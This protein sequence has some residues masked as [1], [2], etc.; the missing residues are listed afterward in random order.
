MLALAAQLGAAATIAATAPA[1]TAASGD[2]VWRELSQRTAGGAD[3]YRGLALTAA[4]QV[5]AAGVTAA[6][7]GA[8]G[9][10]LVRKYSPGG[11][12]LWRR[13]WTWP[14]RSDD[15]AS[16]VARDRRGSFIV[17]GSSGSC[18]LLLKYSAGGYLQWVRRARGQF[19][20]C[21]LTAVAVDGSGD[22]YAAGAATPA[23]GD[24]RIL[25]VKYSSAGA[26]RWQ[27]TLPSA[28]GDAAAAGVALGGGDVYISGR[29]ATGPGTSAATTVKYS[30]G[31]VRRWVRSYAAAPADRA[32]ATSIGFASGP[33]VAGW[34]AAGNAL[35]QGFCVHYTPDGTQSWVATYEGAGVAGDRFDALA[36][37]ADGGACVT[38]SR[39][40]G[41]QEQMLTLAFDA[42][43]ERA[44]EQVSAGATR[45][46]AVCRTAAGICSTGGYSAVLATLVSSTGTPLWGRATSP[47]GYTDFRPAAVQAA[48]ND[49]LYAAGWAARTAGGSAALVIRYR[50]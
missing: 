49:Y 12:V 45:G 4:G 16:A 8:P 7:P 37:A 6:A 1:A 22:V 28:A 24:A 32:G 35:P 44:W 14:G 27:K 9:N 36:V 50:P 41:G 15:A 26:L 21:S 31:G 13:V 34:G 3:A 42:Q 39:W 46:L 23:G 43:G 29:S 5:C 18:W 19:A 47:A 10:V 17:V 11:A 25:V 30:A 2:V 40:S 33:T 48:G 38:G 20:R